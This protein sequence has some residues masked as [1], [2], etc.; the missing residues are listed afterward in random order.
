MVM[1]EQKQRYVEL[2]QTNFFPIFLDEEQFSSAKLSRRWKVGTLRE[3]ERERERKRLRAVRNN[4][5]RNKLCASTF[6]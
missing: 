6:A 4:G 5:A 3:R 1:Q 2:V